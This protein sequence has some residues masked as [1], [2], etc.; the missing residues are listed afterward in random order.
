[1]SKWIIIGSLSAL[2]IGLLVVL[3]LST[4]TWVIASCGIVVVVAALVWF[5]RAI[6]PLRWLRKLRPM[7]IAY[8]KDGMRVKL[9]GQVRCATEPLIAPA[10]ERPCGAWKLS[11]HQ[12]GHRGSSGADAGKTPVGAKKN[13]KGN[14]PNRYEPQRVTDLIIDDGCGVAVIRAAGKQAFL[15][16]TEDGYLRNYI[17]S[18][19]VQKVVR[20]LSD[21]G[22]TLAWLGDQGV[23]HFD[24]AILHLGSR[25]AALGVCHWETQSD[26]T[27][28]VVMESGDPSGGPIWICDDALAVSVNP[29][30]PAIGF[31]LAPPREHNS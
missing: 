6:D 10:S 30:N 17:G 24:E 29:R 23:V 1:V 22:I 3:D 16:L 28:V 31:R 2:A 7:P 4:T 14:S 11:V 15:Y 8:V 9:V 20:R 18:D 13:A 5:I 12:E 21:A 27:R 26:G 19:G 25:V